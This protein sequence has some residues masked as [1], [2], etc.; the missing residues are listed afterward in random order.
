[1]SGGN[2]AINGDLSTALY[3]YAVQYFSTVKAQVNASYPGLLYLGPTTVGGWEAP[4]HKEV[5]QAAAHYVDVLR[6]GFADPNDSSDWAA[7]MS[8]MTQWG[9][10]KPWTIWMGKRA[11]P[12]SYL[13][14]APCQFTATWEYNTQTL[15]G[16]YYKRVL[17]AYYGVQSDGEKHLVGVNFWEWMDLQS[18]CSNW[19]LVTRRDN[20][21]DGVSAVQAPGLDPWGYATGGEL[22][23][24]GDFISAVKAAN[25]GWIRPGPAGRKLK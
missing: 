5:L 21:Y 3:N 7:R 12:D 23:D 10:D 22:K 18:E 1:M 15:R 20:P 16:Q 6:S 19:G 11:N 4:A 25:V 2:S 24:F 17:D 8:F 13:A 9:G 14:A